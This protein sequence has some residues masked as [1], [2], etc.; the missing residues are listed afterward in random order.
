[1]SAGAS[2][3]ALG[4]IDSNVFGAGHHPTTALCIETIEEILTIERVEGVLHVGAGS[5][6]LALTAPAVR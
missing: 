1:M 5:G 4:L 2:P 3:K 6:I